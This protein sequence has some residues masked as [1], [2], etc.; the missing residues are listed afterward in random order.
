MAADGFQTGN[1]IHV[2]CS[3][4]GKPWSTTVQRCPDDG[5]ELVK[6]AVPQDLHV[7]A[8]MPLPGG[9]RQPPEAELSV[10]AT[11]VDG[12]AIGPS[13]SDTSLH[14][15]E[16]HVSELMP[17][18]SPS[19]L[20]DSTGVAVPHLRAKAPRPPGP[21]SSEPPT[22]FVRRFGDHIDLPPGSLVNEE[23][24]IDVK[25][26]AG[27][28]GEVYA[29]RHMRLG[30]RVAIKVIAPR[31]S[32]N[33]DAVERFSREGRALARIHH[34]GIVAVDHVGELADGRAFFVMEYLSGE[35]L[36]ARLE[37]GAVPLDEALDIL[38]QMARALEAAHLHGVTHR[39]LKPA[40]TFLVK[41]PNEPRPIVKLLDFGLAKLAA[42]VER[43]AE[44]TQSGVALGTPMYLSPEQARGPDVDG[45]TD[46]Y[47]LGCLAYE[48]ILGCPPFHEAK[49]AAALIAAH[50]H[51][52]PPRPR[53]IW[54]AIPAALDLVLFSLLAKD[55]AS[56]P[57]LAQVRS[58]IESIRSPMPNG[59]G[60]PRAVAVTGRAP[61]AH[62]SR[63]ALAALVGLAMLGGAVISAA[64]LGRRSG[65]NV[66]PPQLAG[67]PSPTVHAG[68]GS[69]IVAAATPVL[70]AGM[71]VAPRR[72]MD[73]S[74]PP[75]HA[76][77]R[78]DMSHGVQHVT[79]SAPAVAA[80]IPSVA[81]TSRT[82]AI[83]PPVKSATV[84]P[85]AHRP[86]AADRCSTFPVS[87][88]DAP[89]CFIAAC[90]AG[91]EA[92]ARK[93]ITAV[94]AA[95]RDQL[96]ADCKELGVDLTAHKK[97]DPPADDCQADPMA[98]QH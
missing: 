22:A 43:R 13:Q 23:Y 95:R 93:L 17:F 63:A 77:P 74:I 55:P 64:V 72:S 60:Q 20:D 41:L 28:M 6:R 79:A 82:P 26:G 94:A 57:T 44:E 25:L 56:R 34:P 35:P 67:S 5:T 38:D 3:T 88:E 86:T 90:N 87:I 68:D 19:D 30:K 62:T 37:R 70:D 96:T 21:G 45:R 97:P 2:L 31:L 98:C 48:L 76:L 53:S 50:V 75:P 92:R 69:G 71:P 58:V 14:V 32:R 8:T 73:P 33:P 29:A 49:T 24:E 47:A 52:P 27:A 51:E 9:R 66:S 80:P 85:P 11:S 42:D 18:A 16:L 81:G 84:D 65:G 40:N 54:P 39:D 4:C 15:E 7:R 12:V 89:L 36:D 10:E 78:A 59:V 46:V 83:P 91:N 1:K 61:R